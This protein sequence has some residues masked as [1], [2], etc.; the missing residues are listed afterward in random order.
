MMNVFLLPKN[1]RKVV[2]NVNCK[3][4]EIWVVKMP[5]VEPIFYEVG[6][7][8]TMRCYV[9]TIIGRKKK[10]LVAKWDFIEK[11][12]DKRTGFDDKWT[13]DPKFMHVKNEISYAQL[14]ITTFL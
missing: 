1:I 7:V 14:S 6:L 5:W 3:F 8:S 13:M 10:K 4:Q 2:T 11:H 9:C 12:I